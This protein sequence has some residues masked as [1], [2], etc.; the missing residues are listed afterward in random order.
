MQLQSPGQLHLSLDLLAL[1][2][3]LGPLGEIKLCEVAMK[4][5]ISVQVLTHLEI[6]GVFV[7]SLIHGSSVNRL[8]V[9]AGLPFLFFGENFGNK[10]VG[11]GFGHVAHKAREGQGH[12]FLFEGLIKPRTL[13]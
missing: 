13:S 7:L 9:L 6:T 12:P 5:C 3:L 4:G 10:N 1:R 11:L 2:N 8:S